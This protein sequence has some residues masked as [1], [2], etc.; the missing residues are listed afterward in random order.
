ML[1][2]IKTMAVGGSRKGRGEGKGGKVQMKGEK[3]KGK[4]SAGSVNAERHG[5]GDMQKRKER[6][7]MKGRAW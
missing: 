1:T 5:E 3:G 4:L 2:P 7:G 6:G